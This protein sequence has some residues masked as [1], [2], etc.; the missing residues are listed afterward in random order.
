MFQPENG[1]PILS[2]YE[3]R[4]DTKLFDYIPVLKLM[5]SPA[6]QDVRTI[7]SDC[8]SHD[9]AVFLHEKALKDCLKINGDYEK[10]VHTQ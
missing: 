2:W 10:K 7:I 4:A 1:I 9:K 3:D 8:M 5:A 6:I